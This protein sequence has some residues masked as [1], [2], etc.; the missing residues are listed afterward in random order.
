LV[1]ICP[2]IYSR[3][4]GSRI[5]SSLLSGWLDWLMGHYYS[6]M[7]SAEELEHDLQILKEKRATLISNLEHDLNTQGLAYVLANIIEDQKSRWEYNPSRYCRENYIKV[8]SIQ[9]ETSKQN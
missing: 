4:D 9:D 7:V 1:W 2:T 5:A 6:E 8:T 3:I